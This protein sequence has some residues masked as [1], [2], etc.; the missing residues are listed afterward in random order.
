MIDSFFVHFTEEKRPNTA[1][2]LLAHLADVLRIKVILTTNFDS[3]IELAF[4]RFDMPVATFDVHY[5]AVLPDARLVRA[6]RS[7]VK[8]HGGRYGLRADLSL[9]TSPEQNDVE[10][11]L[12]YLSA[13]DGTG[14]QPAKH[15]RDLLVMGI[16]GQERRTVNL[17]CRALLEFGP[18]FPSVY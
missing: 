16:S 18:T 9:D 13:Y 10:N 7:I 3:L 15:Q 2:M 8:L 4:Q 12:A 17:I 5:K 14:R 6:T 1:H 11:F